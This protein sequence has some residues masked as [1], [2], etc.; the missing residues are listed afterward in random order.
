[1]PVG[2]GHDEVNASFIA[3]KVIRGHNFLLIG[4]FFF[5]G[6]FAKLRK[7]TNGFVMSVRPSVRM[8]QLGSHRTDFHEI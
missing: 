2:C 3:D 5:S 8:E 4:P 7:V 6:P 1:M